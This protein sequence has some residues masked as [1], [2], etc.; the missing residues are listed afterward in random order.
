[1]RD[2]D[3]EPPDAADA[4]LQREIRAGREF[5]LADAIGRMAGPGIMKGVS[6]VTREQQA[7]TEIQEYLDRH[8]TDAGRV[9]AGVLLREVSASELLL[10]SFDQPL[11]ALAGCVR[12]VL[13]SEYRLKELVRQTDVDWGHE[14]GERPKFEKE[15]CPPAADD[16]YTLESVRVALTQLAGGLPTGEA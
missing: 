1:M 5:T 7:I 15:G 3:P 6:P 9:L 11:S 16:P 12:Q 8:L 2:D 10:R 4:E 13:N 14:F